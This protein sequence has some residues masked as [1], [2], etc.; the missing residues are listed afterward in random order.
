MKLNRTAITSFAFGAV[1]ATMGIGSA[2]AA[3]EILT[4]SDPASMGQWY[5]RAGGLVGSDRV[6]AVA[7]AANAGSPVRITYDKDVAERTNMPRQEAA[8]GAVTI[9]YDRDVAARTNMSRGDNTKQPTKAV[10]APKET[11]THN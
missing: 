8:N 5:G 10:G 9:T 2:V 11:H 3:A 7:Q 1:M 6:M 4:V